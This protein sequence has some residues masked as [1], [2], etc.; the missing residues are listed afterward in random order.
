MNPSVYRLIAIRKIRWNI[1]T[2]LHPLLDSPLDVPRYGLALLLCQRCHDCRDHFT[3][4]LAGVDA[5]FLE[6]DADAKLFEFPNGCKAVLCI[7]GEPGDA[8]DQNAVDFSFPAI[9]HHA[10]KVFAL[11]NRRAGDALIGVNIDHFP[12]RVVRNKLGIILILDAIG[13]ELIL[14]GGADAGI[15]CDTQLSRYDLI[16]RRDYN[17]ALL[18]QRKVSAGL[19]L[20]HVLTPLCSNTHYHTIGAI[21]MTKTEKNQA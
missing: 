12:I 20:C 7:S 2:I 1:C 8:L 16:V 4:H 11:F 19:L 5:L 9:L 21:A 18:F 3:R 15:C 17:D 13:V 14:A 10:L 6:L